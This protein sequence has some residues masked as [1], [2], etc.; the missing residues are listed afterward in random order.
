MIFN[1]H[2]IIGFLDK[3]SIIRGLY[4]RDSSKKILTIVS[5]SFF[6]LLALAIFADYQRGI[7]DKKSQRIGMSKNSYNHRKFASYDVIPIHPSKLKSV[8]NAQRNL[9]PAP[10]T[11]KSRLLSPEEVAISKVR[12]KYLNYIE[13]SLRLNWKNPTGDNSISSA[14]TIFIE[15]D[16]TVSGYNPL[17]SSDNLIFNNAVLET[18]AKTAPFYPIPKEME[19]P[20]G[21]ALQIY[22]NGAEVQAGARSSRNGYSSYPLPFTKSNITTPKVDEAKDLRTSSSMD[23]MH[24]P[25]FALAKHVQSN[26]APPLDRNS[27]V[28]VAFKLLRNGTVRNIRITRTT[29]DAAAESAA[30]KSI[31]TIKLTNIKDFDERGFI[32]VNYTFEV[33]DKR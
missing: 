10:I 1:L 15:P 33:T 29:G 23:S 27:L 32:N 8:N 16:G 3:L 30:L 18:I 2:L 25:H 5:V 11:G 9:P 17:R 14:Y 24:S 6:A 26:W 22:F 31:R 19:N 13:Y 20:E 28:S 12:S 21:I 7:F 4:V